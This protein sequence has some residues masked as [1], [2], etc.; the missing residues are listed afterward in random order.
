MITMKK[1]PELPMWAELRYGPYENGSHI[2][3]QPNEIGKIIYYHIKNFSDICPN[4]EIWNKVV[5]PDHIHFLLNVQKEIPNHLGVYMAIFKRKVFNHALKENL[6]NSNHN[7]LF[8]PDFNDLFLKR[9]MSLKVL[10]EYILKNPERRWDIQQN[11]QF[12]RRIRKTEICGIDCSMYGNPCLLRNPFI[13]P[14]IVHRRDLADPEI[15]K[16]KQEIWNYAILNGG[17]LVGAFINK[18][19]KAV[20]DQCYHLGGKMIYIRDH[21]LGELEKPKSHAFDLC[22]HG[23][24]LMMMPDFDSSLANDNSAV[25]HYMNDIAIKLGT[26]PGLE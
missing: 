19:E 18:Y 21:K 2:Y 8:I 25:C 23:N 5:M 1:I 9:S 26:W 24:L 10:K 22:K 14:V 12:F 15:L 4:T 3:A 20:R 13:F 7:S 6:I 16:K 17:V 11:P